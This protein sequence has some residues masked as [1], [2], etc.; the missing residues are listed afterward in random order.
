MYLPNGTLLHNRY[1]ID[2]VIGQG[3]FGVTYLAHDSVLNVRV[4]VKEYL[5]RQAAT[6]SEGQIS[7][8]VY[9]GEAR[10]HFEYGLKK[11]LEEAQSVAKF[12]N[13]PNIVSARDYFEA[14][15]TAYMVME[16]IEGVTFKQLLDQHGGKIPFELAKKIMMP[17]MDA[18][19]QVHG[20]G[21]LHRDISPDNIYLTA[22]GQVKLLDFGAAR[23]F[24]GEQ[25]KS[26][27]IILKAGYAPEEQYRSRGK[28]GAW[29]DV[30]AVAATLYRA[31]T[32]VAPPEALD[33]KEEDTIQPPSR[34]EA[35]VT[36]V[37][38][39]VLLKALAVKAPQRFQSMGD[40]QDALQNRRVETPPI[41]QPHLSAPPMS[42][43]RPVPVA[44]PSRPMSRTPPAR[45]VARNRSSATTMAII[46]SL[47][48]VVLVLGGGAAIWLFA[49]R[50]IM[51]KAPQEANAIPKQVVSLSPEPSKLPAKPEAHPSR[52]MI[53]SNKQ[54][55]LPD[56]PTPSAPQRNPAVITGPRWP[57]TSDRLVREQDLAPLTLHDVMI[58]RTEILARHGFVFHRK[59]LQD[60]F[61]K[62]SWYHPDAN[63]NKII[64]KKL[65][66][67]ERENLVFLTKYEKG[68]RPLKPSL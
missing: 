39:Q 46:F 29:T 15:G 22:D 59:D 65:H 35:A 9:S 16:Y 26:L 10:E 44:P 18:L 36:P 38:E 13:H 5:P 23:Y 30:Y 2:R 49:N 4:A 12:A 50:P 25:S 7:V 1:S 11:F 34:L 67:I 63:V 66:N 54:P 52:G 32:G 61:Q 41:I 8:T 21:L 68:K 58:M 37:E 14:N 43:P 3:G 48:A 33:R 6:R 28:Q 62:Q 20:T 45:I 40:F 47:A 19:R 24:A 56:S 64:A 17:V 60:Y 31:I 42:Q 27:S 57:W 51:A 55:V 53:A